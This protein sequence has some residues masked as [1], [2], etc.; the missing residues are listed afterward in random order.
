MKRSTLILS[1]LAGAALLAI[2]A[3]AFAP[4]PLEVE[5]AL[6][7]QGP[8]ETTI[9]EDGR[10]RLAERY[11]VSAPLAGR[12]AR[13]TLREGDAVKAG[14]TVASLQ[15]L[16]TPLL[17]ERS[18]RE[19]LARVQGSEAAL[20]QAGTRVAAARVAL[21]RARDDLRRS[22][23]LAA[24]GFIAPTKL[25][26]D[27]LAVQAAQKDVEAALDGQ[28][29]ARHDLEQARVV[30]NLQRGPAGASPAVMLRA[31]VAGRVLKVHVASEGPVLPGA[32]LLDIGDISRLEIVAELLTTDALQ[33]LPGA[34][35]RIERWGGPGVLQG[36]V[37]RV[38]PAAFTKVSALG[39]E[40][41]RVNVVI[42]I[43]SPRAQWA[44][45][46]DGFRVGV[47][48]VT[49]SEAQVLKLPVGAVFPLP[50]PASG[51]AV[52]VA[53]GG[54]ARLQAV[55]V[56]ARNGEEAWIT[57]GLAAGTRVLIYPPAAVTDGARIRPRTQR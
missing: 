44:A 50:A 38:E 2:L 33:A 31:P 55:T 15:P 41:Q 10:T 16:M 3:W 6:A 53:D 48:I 14:D 54:H 34:L 47:H 30:L 13:I 28:Q 11:Q 40:E 19:Q 37:R 21:E 39:V 57:Q 25:S 49:R 12:L 9:D 27:R 56:A 1:V 17:D 8:F 51:S 45:L 29:I 7:V 32:P 35:V 20:Q 5:T 52:F 46:G 23:Q 4:R 43:N 36:Q 42:D 18:R 26:S 24:Q 22:E